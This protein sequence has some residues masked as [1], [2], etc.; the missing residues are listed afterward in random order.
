MRQQMSGFDRFYLLPFDWEQVDGLRS[1]QSVWF[2]SGHGPF[3]TSKDNTSIDKDCR[4]CRKR[5][6]DSEH[7][8][9]DCDE[10]REI[11]VSRENLQIEEFDRAA[12]RIAAKIFRHG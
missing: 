1:R 10:L 7:L 11:G 4:F 9:F 5:P 6:E 2:L 3:N 8:L 12:R